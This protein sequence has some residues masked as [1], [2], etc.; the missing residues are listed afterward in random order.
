MCWSP[1][2]RG[3]LTRPMDAVTVRGDSDWWGL[4]VLIKPLH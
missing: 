3:L 4:F 2:A 1:L